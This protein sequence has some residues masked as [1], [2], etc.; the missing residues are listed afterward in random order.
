MD[1]DESL[2]RTAVVTVW[3]ALTLLVGF[4]IGMHAFVRIFPS[5][6][7]AA[8][9]YGI[10]GEV[11]LPVVVVSLVAGLGATVAIA[12]CTVF[13]GMHFFGVVERVVVGDR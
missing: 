9:D 6:P 5:I 12:G 8:L 13:A 3:L 10:V 7:A 2:A 1:G 4:W 11:T